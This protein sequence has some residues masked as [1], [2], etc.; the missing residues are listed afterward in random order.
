[1]RLAKEFKKGLN[2]YIKDNIKR[3]YSLSQIKKSFIGNGYEPDFVEKLIKNYR[4]KKS[5]LFTFPFI[6]IFLV[7]LSTFLFYNSDITTFAIIGKDYIFTDDIYLNLD[8]DTD[9]AWNMENKGL[10]KSVKLN[11]EVK[12]N[13]TVKIYLEHGNETYLIF[14][15]KQLEEQ[16]LEEITALAVKGKAKGLETAIN[17]T[18]N[19]TLPNNK[20]LPLEN[21]IPTINETTN[22]TPII[23][24]TTENIIG[25]NLKYKE[26]SIYDKNDDGVE[27]IISAIDFTVENTVF[28]WAVNEENLCTRWDTYSVKDDKSTTVCYGSVRCCNIVDLIPIRPEWNEPFYSVYG[29]DGAS[30]D[31]IISAQVLYVDYNL[32]FTDPFAE[33]YYSEWDNLSGKFYQGFVR[34]ENMCIESC[35]LPNLNATNFNI[36]IEISNSGLILDSISYEILTSEKE[37]NAPI[38]LKNFSDIEIVNNEI[39]KINLS[40]FFYDGDDD[41]LFFNAFNDSKIIINIKNET[42]VLESGNFTGTAYT[43]FT[44]NDTVETAVSNVF[45]VEVKKRRIG[46][47]ILKSLKK[48]IGLI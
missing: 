17:K 18:A 1:M 45:K 34:F 6:L 25:I 4:I 48:L 15:N 30:L 42:A 27:N 26:E 8:Q 37:N 5:L 16:G 13:G 2:L 36:A 23:N 31:N 28:N 10:L 46:P 32:S 11:G 3:G 40:E 44:A 24:E 7:A 12:L 41:I 22:I 47:V 33:V 21:L 19:L 9:F 39:Y 43:F 29:Q 38:L 35:I 20:T 14:D